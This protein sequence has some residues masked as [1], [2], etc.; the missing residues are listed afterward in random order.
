MRGWCPSKIMSLLE[1]SPVLREMLATGEIVGATGERIKVRS[2]ISLVFA[3][4]LYRTV[5]QFQP[6]VVLEVG[7]AYGVSTLA[8]LAALQ[9]LGSDGRLVSIDPHQTIYWHSGGLLNLSRAGLQSRHQWIGESDF[10][11]LPRLLAE[12]F[13]PGLAYIDGWHTFDYT[14]LDLYYIDKMLGVGGVVGLNDCGF[15]AVHKA[16]NFF[17]SHRRYEEITV[18]LPPV[19]SR[20]R[21]IFRRLAGDFSARGRRLCQDRYFKKLEVWEPTHDFFA[22]F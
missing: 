12:G 9:K 6:R 20:K 16:I 13:Q 3:E 22:D 8:I 5:L 1:E 10:L 14:L 4:A 15:P 19:Y 7:M 18:G 21:E 2:Q 17:L 11:A